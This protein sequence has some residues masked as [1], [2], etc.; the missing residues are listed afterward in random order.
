[1]TSSNC[2]KSSLIWI[3]FLLSVFSDCF[4]IFASVVSYL[5][6]LSCMNLFFIWDPFYFSPK[7]R[8]MKSFPVSVLPC[9]GSSPVWALSNCRVFSSISIPFLYE[10]FHITG[11]FPLRSLL[12]YGRNCIN[13]LWIQ[14]RRYY[15]Y[16]IIFITASLQYSAMWGVL[17]DRGCGS[18]YCSIPIT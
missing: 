17:C 11:T 6:V 13:I 18:V 8:S 2:L 12:P 14:I 3:P 15:F 5:L 7:S 1:M 10:F 16:Y 9:C 4:Q